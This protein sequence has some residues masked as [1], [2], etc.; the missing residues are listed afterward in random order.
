MMCGWPR[1]A[2]VISSWGSRPSCVVGKKSIRRGHHSSAAVRMFF[3]LGFHHSL[4]EAS[5]LHV[6]TLPLL[7]LSLSL[8]GS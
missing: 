5:P 6:S 1:A 2:E 8:F 3:H 4:L 7:F